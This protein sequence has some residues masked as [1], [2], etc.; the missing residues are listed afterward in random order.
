[1]ISFYLDN[2]KLGGKELILQESWRQNH[3][4]LRRLFE[5]LYLPSRPSTYRTSFQP[6]VVVP[7]QVTSFSQDDGK[8]SDPTGRSRV[9]TTPSPRLHRASG[10][11]KYRLRYTCVGS[12]KF[13]VWVSS[14]VT[15]R[16]VHLSHSLK[17]RG[18]RI[19]KRKVVSTEPK[20]T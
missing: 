13:R 17:G 2:S 16:G 9:G 1:M 12:E 8:Q 18:T 19:V 5:T 4:R 10:A 11:T 14:R 6:E 3:G 20:P 15:R 7:G